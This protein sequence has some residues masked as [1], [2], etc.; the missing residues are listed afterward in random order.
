MRTERL[1]PAR[2]KHARH[3]PRQRAGAAKSANLLVR[4]DRESKRVLE[5]AAHLRGLTLSDYVRSRIV[6]LARQDVEEAET[7]VLRLPR[8]A[9]V[10]FWQALQNPPPLSRKQRELGRLVREL[11]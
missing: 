3:I 11:L 8:D 4:C 5:R 6:P 2:S 7:S 9:Q 1:S 10:S